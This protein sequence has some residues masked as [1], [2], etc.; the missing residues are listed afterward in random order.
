M[1]SQSYAR[2]SYT[3]ILEAMEADDSVSDEVKEDIIH[4]VLNGRWWSAG[5]DE[6]FGN[7][8]PFAK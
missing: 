6:R 5:L 3:G 2:T 7:A 4:R 8:D 1:I